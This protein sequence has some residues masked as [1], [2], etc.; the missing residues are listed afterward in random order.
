MDEIKLYG[1]TCYAYHGVFEKE[2]IN[3][4]EFILDCSFTMDTSD[5]GDDL[6]KTINYGAVAEFIV[7]FTKSNRFDLLETLG[8][9]LAE[10]L[11]LSYPLM[12]SLTLTIHKPHAPITVPFRDVTLTIT[13]AWHEVYLALGSNLGDK[14]AYLQGAIEGLEL[15]NKTKVERVAKFIATA[16][17]GVLDQPDFLNGAVKIRTLHSPKSLLSLCQSLENKAGREKKRHWGERTLDVDILLYDDLI[18]ST[19]ALSI[20]HKELHLRDFVLTPLAEIAPYV[21]H[22]VEKATILQ[23]KR[24]LE[25]GRG[26]G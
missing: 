3:G 21:V 5:C 16:P 14:R 23:L 12:E 4:Q 15:D 18:F 17:Y 11:L 6:N 8:N 2:K 20:P 19:D 9:T 24:S 25:M 1:L 22:P 13:R 10:A 26:E 7:D